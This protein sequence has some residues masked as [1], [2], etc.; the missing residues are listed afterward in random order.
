[1]R[2]FLLLTILCAAFAA[3]DGFDD[4]LRLYKEGKFK[5]SL[6]AFDKAVQE[7]GADAAPELYYNQALAALAAGDPVAAAAAAER[8]AAREPAR[9][10]RRRDFVH[11]NA[12]FTRCEGVEKEIAAGPVMPQGPQG[13]SSPIVQSMTPNPE[14]FDAAIQLA[15]QARDAWIDASKGAEDW[16]AARRNVERALV[17]IDELR[18]KKEEA[19]K[20]KEEQ[21]KKQQEDDKGDKKDKKKQENPESRPESRPQDEQNPESRP[22]SQPQENP[23]SRPSNPDE[24]K[25]EPKELSQEQLQRLLDKLDEK[26]KQRLQMLR[27]RMRAIRVPKDW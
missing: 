3:G 25:P 6:A 18:K 2:V 1:M 8:A 16:P 23:Q 12:A 20:Q 15:E 7:A 10:A 19:Q 21:E 26:E 4:G 9:F 24:A 13:P 17:K 5:E 22:E 14:A 11:G 27:A